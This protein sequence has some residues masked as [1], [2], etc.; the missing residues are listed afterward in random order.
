MIDFTARQIAGL[1]R[2]Q[3]FEQST[4][5]MLSTILPTLTHTQNTIILIL[6]HMKP[7][8]QGKRG[9]RIPCAILFDLLTQPFE[10]AAFVTS[11]VSP[12]SIVFLGQQR[13]ATKESAFVQADLLL[14]NLVASPG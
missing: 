13:V 4:R 14:S 11:K 10:I 6:W 5:S 9:P 2:L 1:Q 12:V 7:A 8:M 3:L